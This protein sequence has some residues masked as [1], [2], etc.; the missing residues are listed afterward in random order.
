MYMNIKKF[1]VKHWFLIVILVLATV[2]RFYKLGQYPI[3]LTN[4]EA[5][6]GYNAYSILKTGRDEHGTLMPII[7]QSFGDWKPG[8]YVYLTVPSVAILGLTEFAVRF[9]S[10]FAGVAAVY[11]VYL[12]G[13]K[14]FD[15][16][17]G[18][19]AALALALMPWHIHF[20]RGAW[21]ANVALTL[22]LAGLWFLFKSFEKNK[23]LVVSA[24][25]FAL[26]LWTYQSAKL[27]SALPLLAILI[28]YRDKFF[29]IKKHILAKA[30]VIGILISIPVVLSVFNGKGG[31]LEVMSVFSYPRPEEYIQKT[32][33]SQENIQKGDLTYLLFHSEGLNLARGV[34]G[35]YSNYFSGR[36]LFFEGDWSN[37]KHTSPDVGYLLLIDIPILLVGAWS[38][39]SKSKERSYLFV[40]LWLLLAPV[41][42]ALTRDSAHGSE[43]FGSGNTFVFYTCVWNI[44][45]L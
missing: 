36:F 13:K 22:L 11:L 8:F 18:L 12:L 10:A 27:A 38:M 5:A 17:L 16:K 37:P 41:P 14:L 21:E 31:R 32:V 23:Y 26:T 35:R 19:F 28:V 29:S 20:S 39:L 42:A 30:F 34:I 7:F 33:L 25:F 44:R 45:N 40:F 1:F 15:R 2:L 3:H 6:L 4:D 43:I 9:P 24:A